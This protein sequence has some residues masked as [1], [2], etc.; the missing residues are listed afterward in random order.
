M[1]LSTKHETQ[2][3]VQLYDFSG[4]LNTSNAEEMI[5]VNDLSVAINMEIDSGTG[6]IKTVQGTEDIYKDDTKSFTNGFYANI[7]NL[8]ILTDSEQKVY[9]LTTDGK[10]I[11]E[12]GT[13]TGKSLPS[14]ADWE[15]GVII[16]SGGKPQYY[17]GGTLETITDEDS[18]NGLG[19]FV[20]N[21]RIV[22]FY[23]DILKFSGIGNEHNWKNVSNDES[24]A[25]WIQIGY[26]DGGKIIGICNLSSD[27]LVFKDNGHAY[28]LSG[29]YPNWTI[30][31]VGRNIEC[32]G[33]GCYCALVNSVVVL[34]KSTMQ[35][36]TTTQTYGNMRADNIGL[37]VKID[38]A[39]MPQEVKIKYIAPLNQMWM[40]TGNPKFLFFD[41]NCNGFYERQYNREIKDAFVIDN[42]VYVLKPSGVSKLTDS[43]M[44]DSGSPL[45]WEFRARSVPSRNEYLIK[46]CYVDITPYLYK[47]GAYFTI[48]RTMVTADLTTVSNILYHGGK[49]IY[50]NPEYIYGNRTYIV[51]LSSNRY[52]LRCVDREKVIRIHGYGIGNRMLVNSISF[53]IVEV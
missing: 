52:D 9:T 30:N 6:L 51:S 27:I 44:E 15:D 42:N 24:S 5:G 48:G 16:M 35:A 50:H 7:A 21:G 31:E 38:I 22:T 2:Q 43:S 49:E 3:T 46:R 20:K 47:D 12:I 18:P 14:F 37:K 11:K 34:G 17:H 36:I 28:R 25:Q 4:G 19:V 29:N 33:L 13:L 32:K 39:K 40:I 26:K 45:Q 41:A 1:R 10:T 23:D 53:E 8:F